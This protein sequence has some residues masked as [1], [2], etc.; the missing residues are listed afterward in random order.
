MRGGHR[1]VPHTADMAVEA[2]ADSRQECVAE[3]V[4]GLVDSFADLGRSAPGDDVTFL[5]AGESDEELLVEVLQEVI[6]QIDVHGRLAVDA[7]LGEPGAD[8]RVEV[9]L[10]TVP[11]ETAEQVGAMPKAIA[12]HELRFGQ[13][14]GQWR[15]HVVV[16][17]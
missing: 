11:V 14:D 16:D 1:A 3:A 9:R 7:S 17:V 4:R 10:A 5:A 2:W 12:R 8:R 6:Y 15:A 13:A